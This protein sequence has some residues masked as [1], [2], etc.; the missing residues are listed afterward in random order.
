MAE[1]IEALTRKA[2]LGSA[3]LLLV[4]WML[5]FI[6]AGSLHFWQAWVFWALF[7]VSVLLIT[8]YFLRRDPALIERR[9]RAGP[10]AEKQTSQKIIQAL[11][12][13]FFV[14]GFVVAALDH[15]FHWSDVPP[16]LCIVGDLFVVIGFAV[17]FLAFRENTFAS[18]VIE[19]NQG[20]RVV[21]TGVYRFVRHPMYSG[22]ILMQAFTPFALGSFWALLSVPL[23][24]LIIVWR[25]VNE[26]KFLES[27][28]SEYDAYR[29]NT[30]HRLIPFVW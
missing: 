14:L 15:R 30:S 10:S 6:P 5:L 27:H 21:S 17:V 4:L 24:L 29:R 20:Q 18:A 16:L 11:A 13:L 9:L 3:W 2:L 25:L 8:M 7:S 28:L 26:E 19:V 23:M 12:S 1:T 22:A